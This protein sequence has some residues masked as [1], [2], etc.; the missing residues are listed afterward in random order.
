MFEVECWRLNVLRSSSHRDKPADALRPRRSREF[1][2]EC[3]VARHDAHG[4]RTVRHAPE[5]TCITR[6][7]KAKLE[8]SGRSRAQRAHARYPLPLARDDSA[9][10]TGPQRE[11]AANRAA[12]GHGDE[13]TNHAAKCLDVHTSIQ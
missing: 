1:K 10:E 6:G 12:T 3:A 5:D 8:N 7:D 4:F 11:A 13:E 2:R 9:A